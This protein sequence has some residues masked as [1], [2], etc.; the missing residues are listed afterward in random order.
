VI[1]GHLIPAGTGFHIH[2]ESDVRIRPEALLELQA[3]KERIRAARFALLNEPEPAAGR[4]A[5]SGKSLGDV[6]PE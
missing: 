3:E 6:S 2:Q 1:L 4:P 5:A